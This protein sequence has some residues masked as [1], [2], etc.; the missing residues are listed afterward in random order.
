MTTR[1]HGL[2][3]LVAL[4][5][6][7]SVPA[8]SQEAPHTLTHSAKGGAI[9]STVTIGQQPFT[10]MRFPVRDV[11]GGQ[12]Y[13]VTIP[14]TSVG[15]LSSGSIEVSHGSTFATPNTTIDGKPAYVG[16]FETRSES[17]TANGQGT[18]DFTVTSVGYVFVD[19]QLGGVVVS[20]SGVLIGKEPLSNTVAPETEVD[21]GPV[22]NAIAAAEWWKYTE[23]NWLIGQLDDWIDYIRVYTF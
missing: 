10:L 19:I 11:V 3:G 20:I 16:F 14:A 23:P 6:L 1:M 5:G 18:Y 7:V 13:A 17:I 2:F 4:A 9:G 15:G 12:K 22:P 8:W 21:I